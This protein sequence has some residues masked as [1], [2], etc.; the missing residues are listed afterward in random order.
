MPSN[1]REDAPEQ[2]EPVSMDPADF[3]ASSLQGFTQ[4][5][6][7][8]R[9]DAR[10]HAVAAQ[11]LRRLWP[12]GSVP[13]ITKQL[14]RPPRLADVSGLV[15]G[16]PVNMFAAAV[17][18]AVTVTVPDIMGP[19]FWR[20]PLFREYDRQLDVRGLDD[21][22]VNVGMVFTWPGIGDMVLHTWPR[23][24]ELHDRHKGY[25]RIMLLHSKRAKPRLYVLERLETFLDIAV[26]AL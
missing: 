18:Y 25:A 2:F 22:D 9:D 14:G 1:A 21:D 7:Q 12:Q 23:A 8:Q 10:D 15:P 13:A 24:V 17:D 26:E 3:I 4:R 11:V 20:S 6:K 5:T 16:F 19:A